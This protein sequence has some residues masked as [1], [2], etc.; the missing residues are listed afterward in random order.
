MGLTDKITGRVKKA[1]GDLDR[2]RVAAP[3]GPS[4]GAQGRGQGRAAR[5]AGE[6]RREGRR[7]R[8]PRAQDADAE[9]PRI[10]R[11]RYRRGAARRR[12]RR[13]GRRRPGPPRRQDGR[14]QGRRQRERRRQ[15]DREPR[16][17][18][19]SAPTSCR[20]G[21]AARRRAM[22]SR[23]SGCT[24]QRRG[25][26]VVDHGLRPRRPAA[27]PSTASSSSGAHTC[28]RRARLGEAVRVEHERVAGRAARP[29]A[30]CRSRAAR[31]GRAACPARRAPRRGRRARST[32]G[33]G[34]PPQATVTRAGVRERSRCT[35]A[36]VQKRPVAPPAS[37]RIIASPSS[38]R[39]AAGE[40]R[41]TAAARI[42]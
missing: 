25:H 6:G 24:P 38:R 9:N 19:L 27:P 41:R 16:L 7:G 14:G 40:R 11:R 8:E 28:V 34:C 36:I 15:G 35:H 22:S 12:R 13:T 3:R 32:T 29:C 21:P 20:A 18:R 17:G 10:V 5:A 39:I 2:R 37:W 4:G 31:P 42:V 26:R 30:S 33:S 1:A 23:G